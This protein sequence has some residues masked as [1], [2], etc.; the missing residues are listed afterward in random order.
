MDN[1]NF[2]WATGFE[3]T[4]IPQSR[5]GFRSLDEYQLTQHYQQWK[6]DLDLAA[7]T[8]VSGLRWGIPWYRVQPT[9]K[10]WDW[11]WCDQ[12]LD[13]MVNTKKLMP[14][15]DLVH[16]GTPLW[17]EN[18]FINS[19]FPQRVAEYAFAVAERYKSLVRH[20]TP[21]NEAS[22]TADRCGRRSEWPPYLVGE[23]GY[24]KVLLAL[25]R[26]LVLTVRAL[27]SAQPD[28]ISVHVKSLWHQS[29]RNL[30]LVEEAMEAN[31]H[32]YLTF[33]LATGRLNEQHPQYEYLAWYG[34][35][36]TEM[37]WFLEHAVSFD[38][39]GANF[40]PWSYTRLVESGSGSG[41]KQAVGA[42]SG[43]MISIAI[44]D[45]YERYRLPVMIT[46]TSAKADISGRKKWMDETVAAVRKMRLAGI[47]VVGYTWYPLI[48]MIDWSYRSG[49]G[50]LS[51]YLL[52]LGLYDA[53]FDRR[54]VLQRQRTDLVDHYR[55]HM[56]ESL[57]PVTPHG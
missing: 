50:P 22:V 4:F 2:T 39:F 32:Q 49:R 13:Y 3:D 42:S 16:Y 18:S 43:G 6:A 36:E 34:F 19:S 11:S 48:S 57:P 28:M 54:G 44:K 26:G 37:R 15:L 14:I 53:Q 1:H 56:S 5:Q 40:Y 46:E 9:P 51:Q 55:Q 52:H 35:S 47:P 17:L 41:V 45:A 8:G 7:D 24:V 30:A 20:Y 25:A 33:D 10:T 23:D 21:L 38:I 31:Q 27:R 29:T 12:V